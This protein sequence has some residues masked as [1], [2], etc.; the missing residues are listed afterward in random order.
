M[1]IKANQNLYKNILVGFA[2]V[3]IFMETLAFFLGF[4]INTKSILHY[5]VFLI[6]TIIFFFVIF[7]I[8]DK[9]NKKHIVF[10][11]G[12]IIEKNGADER[13]IVYYNQILRT[14]YH[15]KIDL[16]FGIVDFGY[17]EIVYKINP[18]DKELKYLHLYLSPKDYKEIFVKPMSKKCL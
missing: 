4:N 15:N 11:K 14:K 2:S 5:V 8:V 7:L 3:F 10:D 17:V 16:M 18:K 12:K 9:M 6:S 13:V 1:V